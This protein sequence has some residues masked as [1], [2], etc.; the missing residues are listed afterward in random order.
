MWMSVSLGIFNMKRRGQDGMGEIN[1]RIFSLR[2]KL[3]IQPLHSLRLEK[4]KTSLYEC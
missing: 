3:L 1:S 2:K 4:A